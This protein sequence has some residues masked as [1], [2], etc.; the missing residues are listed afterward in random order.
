M[1]PIGSDTSPPALILGAPL[2]S[3][4]KPYPEDISPSLRGAQATKQ[5]IERRTRLWIASLT[6]RRLAPSR[7]LAMTVDDTEYDQNSKITELAALAWREPNAQVRG[8]W[9]RAP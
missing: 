6:G 1:K 2:A 5:S 8:V 9:S 4:A 3:V 7:W